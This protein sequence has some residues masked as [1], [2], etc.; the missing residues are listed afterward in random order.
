MA[1]GK[2]KEKAKA[3]SN[4]SS[5]KLASKAKSKSPAMQ[6]QTQDEL[7]RENQLGPAP[8]VSE[9]QPF[10][11]APPLPPALVYLRKLATIPALRKGQQGGQ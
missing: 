9:P 7:E 5:S 8:F 6:A 1:N 4:S 11:Q 2:L 10:N 3:N